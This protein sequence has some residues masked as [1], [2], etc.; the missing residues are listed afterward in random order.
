MTDWGRHL[1]LSNRPRR[2]ESAVTGDRSRPA[3]AVLIALADALAAQPGL[4]TAPTLVDGVS[5]D[6]ALRLA[7]TR[8]RW[9]AWQRIL[10]AVG[11]LDA[12]SDEL[13]AV[14]ATDLPEVLRVE[15]ADRLAGRRPTGVRPLGE[16]VVVALDIA[17]RHALPLTIDPDA[18]GA[19]ALDLAMRQ[20]IDRRA[21]LQT[22]ALRAVDGGWQ[23]GAGRPLYAR[24]AGIVLFLAGLAGLPEELP[25]PPAAP[26]TDDER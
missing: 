20:P 13:A 11:I 23:V 22:R 25:E 15:A 18:L 8:M 14:D 16:A 17:T 19:V 1:P 5:V 12:P 2:D 4:V 6:R 24:S 9:S 3:A 21:V 10:A 26:V 7:V